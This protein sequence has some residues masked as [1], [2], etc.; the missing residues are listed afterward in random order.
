ML[1]SGLDYIGALSSGIW[2]ELGEPTSVSVPSISGWFMTN[3][4]RLNNHLMICTAPATGIVAQ[5]GWLFYPMELTPIELDVYAMLYEYSYYNTQIANIY[6]GI[7]LIANMYRSLK[8]G[9]TAITK[10]TSLD[11]AKAM[12]TLRDQ[13]M[14][15]IKWKS[16]LY[17]IGQAVPASVNSVIYAV[18]GTN[19]NINTAITI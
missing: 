18:Y 8:E 6:N 17:R 2:Q 5:S 3:I 7:G 12:K 9:D 1:Y 13:L 11:A 19:Y 16:S 14:Q 10:D 4:G 15:D